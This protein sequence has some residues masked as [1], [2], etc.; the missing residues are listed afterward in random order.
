M[1]AEW[2]VSPP[3]CNQLAG[4]TD[5]CGPSGR[6][7]L[8]EDARRGNHDLTTAGHLGNVGSYLPTMK[9]LGEL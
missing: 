4:S 1:R 2:S 5:F 6:S 9:Y 7:C 8:A 3:W